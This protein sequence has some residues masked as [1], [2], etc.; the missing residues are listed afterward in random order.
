MV[1]LSSPEN[2]E[3][4]SH[5]QWS[6]AALLVSHCLYSSPLSALSSDRPCMSL[7]VCVVEYLEAFME[8]QETCWEYQEASMEYQEV[9]VEC[10]KVFVEYQETF[11]EY[12]DVF[13][14]Y[15]TFL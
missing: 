13:L 6:A 15:Q 4:L 3:S 2:R 1:G 12:Q 9:F 11:V 10:Q 7:C 5:S 14:E 8:Y